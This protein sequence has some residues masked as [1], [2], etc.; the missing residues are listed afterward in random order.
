MPFRKV[1]TTD[2]SISILSEGV[3]LTGEISF[4]NELLVNGVIKGQ[5]KS[6]ATL[7]IGPTGK[8]DAEVNVKKVLI[9]GEFHGTIRASD[10]VEIHKDGRV[11]G[12]IYSPC[13]IIEAGAFFDGHCNM[14]HG[15]QTLLEEEKVTLKA[16]PD[17]G[18]TSP[19]VAG[20]IKKQS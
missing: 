12:E 14:G 6:E 20:P 16:N 3:E 7:E 10:R 13:L 15:K 9:D 8:V 17:F 11:F 5:I 18:K 1:K 4:A 2:T 19:H